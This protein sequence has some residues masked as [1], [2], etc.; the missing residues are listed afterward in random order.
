MCAG[1]IVHEN[2]PFSHPRDP[3]QQNVPSMFAGEHVHEHE[4]VAGPSTIE[5]KNRKKRAAKVLSP[6][7]AAKRIKLPVEADHFYTKYLRKKMFKE[8]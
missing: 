3:V 6:V 2:L 4:P 8:K 1:N 7:Q 5:K